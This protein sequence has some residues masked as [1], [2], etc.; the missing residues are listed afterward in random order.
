MMLTFATCNTLNLAMPGKPFYPNDEP[1][2]VDQYRRK[3]AW[4]GSQVAR[5]NADVVAFEEVWDENALQEAI[6]A[7]GTDY[8]TV[9]VPGAEGVGGQANYFAT[10]TPRLGLATRLP[11]QS[12]D[13]VRDFAPG[14][15]VEVPELGHITRFERPVLR[16]VLRLPALA[17]GA[18][19]PP[20]TVLVAHLKSKRPKFLQDDQGH[21]LE[22]RDDPLVQARAALRSL[23]M[24][25]AEAAAL[26]QIVVQALR[27]TRTPLVLMG[28]LNDGP[29]AVTTQ[30]IAATSLSPL[31]RAERD[32]MLY[33]AYDVQ[34]EPTVRRQHN[35]G[36][37]THL[38]QGMPE[39][40]D[41]VFVSEEFNAASRFSLGRVKRV[42]YFNDHLQEGR[43][44]TKSDH[45]FVRAWVQLDDGEAV[46]G[47]AAPREADS[48]SVKAAAPLASGQ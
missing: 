43:D 42:D 26:R 20:L 46:P 5:L 2:S 38:H 6:S 21:A 10:A 17:S 1:W 28:D 30:L 3:I 27:G 18:P 11:V 32:T 44:K 25:G 4:L 39:A 24:R 45:G 7:G 41:H 14:H 40:L 13:T 19:R 35:D 15:A 8:A 9:R 22:D 47:R 36:A 48:N 37:Y 12:L 16:A 23:I 33:N 29:Q 34:A 31:D